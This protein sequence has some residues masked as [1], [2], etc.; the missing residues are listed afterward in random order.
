MKGLSSLHLRPDAYSPAE[1]VL[2]TQIGAPAQSGPY[3]SIDLGQLDEG[4]LA[5]L[6]NLYHL[7]HAL[8]TSAGGEMLASA[9]MQPA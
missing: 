4:D 1:Q 5:V 8:E 6:D 2:P 7:C 3:G 9:M